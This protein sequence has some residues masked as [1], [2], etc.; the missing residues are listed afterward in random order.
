MAAHEW[1]RAERRKHTRF[2]QGWPLDVMEFLF[3]TFK[4][5]AIVACKGALPVLAL[6][7]IWRGAHAVYAPLGWIAVGSLVWIDY[8]VGAFL[9]RITRMNTD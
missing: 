8:S 7:M 4:R 3:P 6:W 2:V 9:P 5:A 1:I